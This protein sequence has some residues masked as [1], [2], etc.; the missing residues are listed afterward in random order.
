MIFL[1]KEL[2]RCKQLPVFKPY[3]F[4]RCGSYTPDTDISYLQPNIEMIDNHLH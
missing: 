1:N 3:K 4:R 2:K